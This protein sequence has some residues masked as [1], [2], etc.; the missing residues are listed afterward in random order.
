MFYTVYRHIILYFYMQPSKCFYYIIPSN[1]VYALVLL[2]EVVWIF[3]YMVS[4]IDRWIVAGIHMFDKGR[5]QV[6]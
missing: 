3:P 1:T 5:A 2:G 6:V 4:E